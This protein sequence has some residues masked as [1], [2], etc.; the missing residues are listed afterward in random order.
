MSKHYIVW[1]VVLLFGVSDGGD[2]KYFKNPCNCTCSNIPAD[3][4]CTSCYSAS[5]TSHYRQTKA[6]VSELITDSQCH[7]SCYDHLQSTEDKDIYNG[8]LIT[9]DRICEPWKAVMFNDANAMYQIKGITYA[10]NYKTLLFEIPLPK[11]LPPIAEFPGLLKVSTAVFG[12]TDELSYN[13]Y[14]CDSRCCKQVVVTRSSIDNTCEN[15]MSKCTARK[16]SSD[17]IL[18]RCSEDPV[19]NKCLIWVPCVKNDRDVIVIVVSVCVALFV[20]SFCVR[21]YMYPFY[22]NSAFSVW[23]VSAVLLTIGIS[24]FVA[25]SDFNHWVEYTEVDKGYASYQSCVAYCNSKALDT[26]DIINN[27]CLDG[28]N[29]KNPYAVWDVDFNPYVNDGC[30]GSPATSYC[31]GC[32]REFDRWKETMASAD[33]LFVKFIILVVECVLLCFVETVYAYCL[34]SL[35]NGSNRGWYATFR[36]LMFWFGGILVVLNFILFITSIVRLFPTSRNYGQIFLVSSILQL[37]GGGIQVRDIS[38]VGVF[39]DFLVI[40]WAVVAFNFMYESF[41][42]HLVW[43]DSDGFPR[44]SRR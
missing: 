10:K 7:M 11:A 44:R 27:M 41:R 9:R 21:I 13:N 36:G 38:F 33:Y 26:N 43:H 39:F 8:V 1:C 35:D 42:L 3:P 4:A 28:K 15:D 31:K 24:S 2:I 40:I 23:C 30:I 6:G 16:S 29:L 18:S 22:G 5:D 12:T 19:S 14:T 32:V 20:V 34:Y 17:G 37:Q 25:S